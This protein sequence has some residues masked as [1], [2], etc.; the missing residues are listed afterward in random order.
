MNGSHLQR[1]GGGELDQGIGERAE[2][3]FEGVTGDEAGTGG[4]SNTADITNAEVVLNRVGQLG[5]IINI[6]I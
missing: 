2:V 5:D 3:V 1:T 4:N 6:S